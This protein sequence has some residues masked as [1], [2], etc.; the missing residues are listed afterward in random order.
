MNRRFTIKNRLLLS[1]VLT[2]VVLIIFAILSAY[3]NYSQYNDGVSTRYVVQIS[4]KLSAL[5]H[6]LQK[7][8]GASAGFVGSK[9][10]KFKGILTKQHQD[11]DSKKEDYL[12][13]LS[14]D[15]NPYNALARSKVDLSKLQG[16][17][18]QVKSLDIKAPDLIAYYTNLNKDIIDTIAMLSTKAKEIKTRN[19]LNAFSIF[20]TAKERAGIERAVLSNAFAQDKFS[21]AIYAKFIEVTTQQKVLLNL[22][23]TMADPKFNTL[24]A[25]FSKDPSFV[26]VE[27]MRQIA[28]SRDDGFGIDATSWFATITKKINKLKAFEDSMAQ[29]ILNKADAN[30][31]D[32]VINLLIE[33]SGILIAM[34]ILIFTTRKI[35]NTIN[36]SILHLKLA[37]AS[38][39]EGDLSVAIDNRDIS[40][41]EMGD[42]AQL[43]SSLVK[44]IEQLTSR[45]N[46]SVNKAAQGDFSL[47]ISSDGLKGDYAKAISMVGSGIKAMQTAH[48]KQL[49]I[50]FRSAV[51]SVG[52]LGESLSLMQGEVETTIDGLHSVKQ[53]A[54]STSETSTQTVSAVD[55]V[56]DE[57]SNLIALIAENHSATEALNA[58]SNEITSVIDL[59]KDIADQTN[60][61]ALNAAIEAARAGEHGRGFAVV[62]DEVRKLAEKTQKATQEISISIDT[63]RQE[64]DNITEKSQVMSTIANN[65]SD[66]IDSFH[67]TMQAFDEEAKTVANLVYNIENQVSIVL[68]KIL[69]IIFKSDTYNSIIEGKNTELIDANRENRVEAWYHQ[70]AKESF[71]QTNTYTHLLTPEHK[72]TQKFQE[73]LKL[74]LD[75]NDR[76]INQSRVVSLLEEM[77]HASDDFF[78]ALDQMRDEAKL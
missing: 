17:R 27:Q 61:L 75:N 57:L 74:S 5:V 47:Q 6:E 50:N 10:E 68:S 73:S 28:Q 2:I 64:S 1:S 63:M 39:N 26:Q 46:T 7:E 4:L 78:K 14:D 23:T 44:K 12:T 11:T 24:L 66:S 38:V 48:E 3:K 16:I 13:Y 29:M 41:D 21:R 37:I 45:I 15:T 25:E 56:R 62:A 55:Q 53:S 35:S 19:A 59:I 49:E 76:I 58:K 9:G 67:S 22:F 34:I 71:G 8:R 18:N 51:Q 36:R 70:K 77:E 65:S 30:I 60:L 42:I 72:V 69:H 54:H 43:I 20:V 32:A 33:L 31:Q 52:N 40:R